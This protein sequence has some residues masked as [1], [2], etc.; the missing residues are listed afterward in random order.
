MKVYL[1]IL[2]LFLFFTNL[3]SSQ[4]L[5]PNPGFEDVNVCVTYEEKC[6][7][8]AWRNVE[9]KGFQFPEIIV[10]RESGLKTY[11][12]IRSARIPMY[13]KRRKFDRIFIQTPLLCE[14]EEGKEYELE[15]Y[16]LLESEAVKA[17]GLQFLDTISIVD[18]N[19]VFKDS[20]PDIEVKLNPK[21]YLTWQK[22]TAKYT[23]TGGE[24]AIL[25]GNFKSDDDTELALVKKKKKRDTYPSRIMVWLDGFS[26]KVL[27]GSPACNEMEE[28]RTRIYQ[29][30]VRHF[31]RSIR[32]VRDIE[33]ERNKKHE[34]PEDTVE[35]KNLVKEELTIEETRIPNETRIVEE[36]SFV[37]VDI[38]FES[39]SAKL[40]PEAYPS[41]EELYIYMSDYPSKSIYITGH[42]DDMGTEKA[43]LVLSRRRAESVAAVLIEKGISPSRISSQGKGE[44]MPI[45]TNDTSEGRRKNRRVEFLLK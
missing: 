38:N 20:V 11:D 42:T 5:I 19:W 40:L 10:P 44:L 30:S 35:M 45:T 24:Q 43:N 34:E 26:L 4:N 28:N 32:L 29:D 1:K 16:Y 37:L 33:R 21:H 9:L 18:K 23:A 14:L 27:D 39:N 7:P 8:Q 36:S 3:L 31:H 2:F 41:L 25:L 17:F 6:S 12:G 15:F 22:A 13:N